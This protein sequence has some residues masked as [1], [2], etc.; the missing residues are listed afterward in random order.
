MVQIHPPQWEEGRWRLSRLKPGGP[1]FHVCMLVRV[2]G[3]IR[4][5]ASFNSPR[6]VFVELGM[7]TGPPMGPMVG[8]FGY[9]YAWPQLFALTFVA[10]VVYGGARADDAALPHRE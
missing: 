3:H 5:L 8:L 10:H 7:M 4:Y 1:F 9:N 2:L 6:S